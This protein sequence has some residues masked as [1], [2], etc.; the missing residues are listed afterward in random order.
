MGEP[1]GANRDLGAGRG[2]QMGGEPTRKTA[3]DAGMRR[4]AQIRAAEAGGWWLWEMFRLTAFA[5]G[6]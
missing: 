6:E 2:Q 3:V 5:P 1:P 4:R